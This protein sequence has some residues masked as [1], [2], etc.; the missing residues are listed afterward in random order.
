MMLTSV[1]EIL[2]E[3]FIAS[4]LS[5]VSLVEGFHVLLTPGRHFPGS[6]NIIPK[7]ALSDL[8]HALDR[9]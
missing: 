3:S 9:L 2:V 5:L 1:Y 6:A 8:R 7:G 4:P